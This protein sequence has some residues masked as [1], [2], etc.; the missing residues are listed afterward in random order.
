[1]NAGGSN[2]KDVFEEF[3]LVI[4]IHEHQVNFDLVYCCRFSTYR[5][6]MTFPDPY[7]IQKE[8]FQ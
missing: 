2:E 7:Y 3:Q 6:K 5:A 4:F 8:G 1:M